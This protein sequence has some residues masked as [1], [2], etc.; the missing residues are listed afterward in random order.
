MFDWINSFQFTVGEALLLILWSQGGLYTSTVHMHRY[1][2]GLRIHWFW[3]L[4][5]SVLA[6]PG[7][8]IA[9]PMHMVLGLAYG[10]AGYDKDQIEGF[11]RAS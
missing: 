6:G 1:R 4:V 7:Y 8:W 11:D 10:F 2:K 9:A 5:L 3:S